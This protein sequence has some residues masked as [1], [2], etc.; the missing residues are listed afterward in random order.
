MH[1]ELDKHFT[2]AA[3]LPTCDQITPGIFQ[4]RRHPLTKAKTIVYSS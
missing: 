2:S 1:S 4:T 3:I